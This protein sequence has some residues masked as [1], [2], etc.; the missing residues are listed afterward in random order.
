MRSALSFLAI[1]LSVNLASCS[2]PNGK[3][4]FIVDCVQS[5]QP[6]RS[7]LAYYNSV[8]PDSQSK[9][10]AQSTIYPTN[11]NNQYQSAGQNDGLGSYSINITQDYGEGKVTGTFTPS[12]ALAPWKC[13]GYD[14]KLMYTDTSHASSASPFAQCISRHYCVPNPFGGSFTAQLLLATDCTGD[15]SGVSSGDNANSPGHGVDLP[16]H[17]KRC[18]ISPEHTLTVYLNDASGAQI[19][20]AQQDVGADYSDAIGDHHLCGA[21][22][23]IT[24]L[25]L[26]SADMK[27][28]IIAA[29]GS[30]INCGVQSC[31]DTYGGGFFSTTQT[32][33]YS[34]SWGYQ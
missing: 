8:N 14:G 19:C 16:K 29:D 32:Y 18:S 1:C 6:I 22:V 24:D 5:R 7:Y 13:Y 25:N 31:A 30:T 10:D 21:T 3:A 15:D 4:V 12:S 17:K 27:A 28:Q 34:C 9:P 26:S 20:T 33:V 23:S 11:G 2:T